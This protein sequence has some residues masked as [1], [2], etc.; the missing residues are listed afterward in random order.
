VEYLNLTSWIL[1]LLLIGIG[2]VLRTQY[3]TELKSHKRDL[4]RLANTQTMLRRISQAVESTSDAIGIGDI[5]GKS[6]YLNHAHTEM[7]GYTVRELNAVADR[8]AVL[9]EDKAIAAE[10]FNQISAGESWHGETT[11][12]AK[13]GSRIPVSVRADAIRDNV[14]KIVGIY[15]VFTDVSD[16]QI[17]QQQLRSERARLRVTLESIADGVITT[18]SKG[19]IVLMNS[20]AERLTGWSRADA[21]G[22]PLEAVMHL[23]DVSTRQTISSPALRMLRAGDGSTLGH[24]YILQSRDGRERTIAESASFI[25]GSDGRVSG[26]VQVLRD[27]TEERKHAAESA[28]ALRLES[29]GLLAGGIAHD[30]NNLLTTMICNL[31]LARHAPGLPEVSAKRLD[32]LEHVIWRA[33]D[34]TENLKTFAKGDV[35]K[36]HPVTLLGLI[37][38]AASDAVLGKNVSVVYA[39]PETLHQVEADYSQ[40]EQVIGNIV[41]N[42]AQAMPEGG[43][44]TIT[45]RNHIV[46]GDAGTNTGLSWVDIAISDEGPGM[47]PELLPKIFDPFF[48]T[49]EKGTGLG[50][51]TAHTI[52]RGH[53]GQLRVESE[54]GKGT[55]FHLSLPA[56]RPPAGEIQF[57]EE[58]ADG[59]QLIG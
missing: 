43:T 38:E 7:F 41:L 24:D 32:D 22:R 34:L 55:T 31:H 19:E 11:A 51:A 16:R 52:M 59:D 21:A 1:V 44:I 48:T 58:Q 56:Y 17:S 36:K 47:N 2:V 53:G 26:L 23:L 12:V 42:S 9:F 10:V 45:A 18:D 54:W 29:L 5:D 3:Q 40:I 28:R 37:R 4:Q 30:F 15:V 46:A 27:V 6:L 35:P 20:V 8:G 39:I 13:D 57:A 33:H 14:G 49:K 50:L 25:R